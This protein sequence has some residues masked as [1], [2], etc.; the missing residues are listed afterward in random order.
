M[1]NLVSAILRCHFGST[2][3]IDPAK[4]EAWMDGD[5]REDIW[6]YSVIH[7]YGQTAAK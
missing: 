7:C 1:Q 2:R 3:L 6:V 4:G 5:P